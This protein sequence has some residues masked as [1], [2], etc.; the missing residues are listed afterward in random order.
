MARSGA[1]RRTGTAP[2]TVA[3]TRPE[4]RRGG[5]DCNSDQPSPMARTEAL[6]PV[7]AHRAQS[8]EFCDGSAGRSDLVTGA[9]GEGVRAERQPDAVDI[10]VAEHLSGLVAPD[11][12]GRDQLL[13]PDRAA[14]GEQPGDVAHVHHLVLDTEPVPE[15]LALGQPHLD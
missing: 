14:L 13:R 15:A 2:D 9:A 1:G 12:A 3:R 10:A 8:L 6:A 5:V 11:H 4:M 7:R